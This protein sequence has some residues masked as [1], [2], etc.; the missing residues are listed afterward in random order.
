MYAKHGFI[1]RKGEQLVV[2]ESKA[3][4]V[5]DELKALFETILDA[6]VRLFLC[7]YLYV[8][9]C[10]SLCFLSFPFPSCLM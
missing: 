10:L 9:V 1:T 4:Q 2:D 3:L 6:E 7:V 8:C 5:L